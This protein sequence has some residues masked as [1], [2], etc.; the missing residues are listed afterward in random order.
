MAKIYDVGIVGI[1]SVRNYGTNLTYYALYHALREMGLT[2]LMIERPLDAAWAP[3]LQDTKSLPLFSTESI[4]EEDLSEIFATK[5][6]MKA[7]NWRC[8]T[9]VLGSDQMLRNSHYQQFN[10]FVNL[11][12]VFDSK[13]KI[14]YAA[15]FGTEDIGDACIDGPSK[16]YFFQK[17][18]AFSVREASAVTLMRDAYGVFATQVLDPVFLCDPQKFKDKAAKGQNYPADSFVGG[19]ILDPDPEKAALIR[20]I[21]KRVGASSLNIISDTPRSAEQLK[22]RWD[23]PPVLNASCEDWL[24]NIQ[25]SEV[26]VTDSF[27]GMCLAIILRKH[28]IPICNPLRGATRMKS[29]LDTAGLAPRLVADTAVSFERLDELMQP[30]D[31]EQVYAR[32]QERILQSKDWLAKALFDESA[33]IK[34]ATTYDILDMRCDRISIALRNEIQRLSQ[35]ILELEEKIR[36]LES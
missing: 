14:A 6:A 24:A 12:W 8:K 27:H 28:F 33:Q 9:F 21:A 29:L 3:F 36:K 31:Y 32:L 2:A 17:F 16:A 34:P 7:L 35:H 19:Y 22:E 26:F 11:S 30:I 13:R 1:W 20:E 4:P 25:R 5:G 10:Q 23:I 18:D 15:S